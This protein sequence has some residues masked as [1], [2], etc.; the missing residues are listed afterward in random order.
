MT[1]SGGQ[2][3]K[4]E[5]A[6]LSTELEDKGRRMCNSSQDLMVRKAMT[7]NNTTGKTDAGSNQANNPATL[8]NR[9]E[10]KLMR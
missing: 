1:K 10:L 8:Q 6:R 9:L 7:K 5:D 2:P 3:R 4:L